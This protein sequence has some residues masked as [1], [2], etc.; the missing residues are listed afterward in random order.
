MAQGGKME[1]ENIHRS[2][3]FRYKLNAY[4]LDVQGV[5]YALKLNGCWFLMDVLAVTLEKGRN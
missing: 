4:A 3:E 2:R 1:V 5:Q